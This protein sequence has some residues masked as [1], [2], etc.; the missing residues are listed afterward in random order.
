[1]GTSRDTGPSR[2]PTDGLG[3]SKIKFMF[4]VSIGI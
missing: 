1:M 4:V 3:P 2:V